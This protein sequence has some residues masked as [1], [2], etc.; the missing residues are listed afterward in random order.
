[1]GR[2]PRATWKSL[3]QLLPFAAS[4]RLPLRT[5][6]PSPLVEVKR[7]SDIDLPRDFD[8]VVDLDAKV[9]DGAFYFGMSEQS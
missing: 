6:R 3:S 4:G 9:P 1:M 2:A 7:P 8:R 5:R